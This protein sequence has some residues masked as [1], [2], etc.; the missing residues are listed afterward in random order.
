MAKGVAAS[1]EDAVLHMMETPEFAEATKAVVEDSVD[2][3]LEHWSARLTVQVWGRLDVTDSKMETQ[4]HLLS[5][6]FDR[7]TGKYT[8]IRIWENPNDAS[9]YLVM[10]QLVPHK[11]WKNEFSSIAE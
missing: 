1:G 10:A 4:R 9:D 3:V 7:S 2:K 6:V 5:F 11:K 8:P